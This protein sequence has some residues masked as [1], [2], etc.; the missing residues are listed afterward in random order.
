[1]PDIF[2]NT[3]CD[4]AL[5]TRLQR[6]YLLLDLAW[7]GERGAPIW[8]LESSLYRVIM[9]HDEAAAYVHD[10]VALGD[11]EEVEPERYVYTGGTALM[12]HLE[13]ALERGREQYGHL[14]FRSYRRAS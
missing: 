6:P 14:D 4:G 2:P 3:E 12:A 5:G 13:S 11:L 10:L 9:A 8:K 7:G 1:M